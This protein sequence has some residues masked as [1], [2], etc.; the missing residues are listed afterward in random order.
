LRQ[1]LD[2]QPAT[3]KNG[4]GHVNSLLIDSLYAR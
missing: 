2:F 4:I 3:I 1:W